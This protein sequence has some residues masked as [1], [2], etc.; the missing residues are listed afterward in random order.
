MCDAAKQICFVDMPFGDKVDPKSGME[1][2]FDQVFERGIAPVA[3]DGAAEHPGRGLEGNV[4][5]VPVRLGSRD[6]AAG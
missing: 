1:V 3:V 5:G 6:F 4:N 2:D